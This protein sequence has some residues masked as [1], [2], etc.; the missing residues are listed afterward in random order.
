MI[1]PVLR[2]HLYRHKQGHQGHSSSCYRLGTLGLERLRYAVNQCQH[3]KADPYAERVERACVRIVTLTR[4]V[5]SLVQIHHDS[6]TCQQEQQRG[7]CERAKTYVVRECLAQPV[8][9]ALT[10]IG[11]C[12]LPYETYQTQ[13]Q[14]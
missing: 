14:R 4:L 7:D 8:L 1:V 6:Q 13:Q 12:S 5:R 10:L 9:L 2:S 3:A 11:L